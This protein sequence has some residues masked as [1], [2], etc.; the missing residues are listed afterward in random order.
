MQEPNRNMSSEHWQDEPEAE[1]WP[2]AKS[3]L[4]LLVGPS[5]AVKLV[6]AL[7]KEQEL[8]RHGRPR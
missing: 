2:A 6:K 5:G 8:R 4:S 1:D 3:Y 7:P